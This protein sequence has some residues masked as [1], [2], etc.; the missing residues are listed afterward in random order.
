MSE[1][2][3]YSTQTI[4]N[5]IEDTESTLE[6]LKAEMQRRE[7]AEQEIQI[8]GLENHM[9]SAEFSLRSIREFLAF[10]VEEY[11]RGK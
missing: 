1:F 8:E 2:K 7:E 3:H 10:L 4:R 6:Q 11:R 5:L 9:K